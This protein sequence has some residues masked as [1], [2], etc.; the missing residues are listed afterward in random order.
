MF[1]RNTVI[2]GKNMYMIHTKCY[3]NLPLLA[4]ACFYNTVFV[5][6]L[7]GNFPIYRVSLV[8]V[9]DPTY[10]MGFIFVCPK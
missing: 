8:L 9:V 7:A 2:F 5:I 6:K 10:D 3:Y 4:E 1:L